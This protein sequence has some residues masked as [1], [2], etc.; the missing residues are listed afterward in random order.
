MSAKHAYLVFASLYL[1]SFFVLTSWFI[2]LM[3]GMFESHVLRFANEIAVPTL[4]GS[5]VCLTI[6]KWLTARTYK[7]VLG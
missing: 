7:R 4:L 5:V 2:L 3:V 6:F 1:L